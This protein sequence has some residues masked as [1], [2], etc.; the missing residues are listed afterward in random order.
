MKTVHL[1][2]IIGIAIVFAIENLHYVAAECANKQDGLISCSEVDFKAAINKLIYENSEHPL[3]LVSG[4]PGKILSLVV[5][6]DLGHQKLSDTITMGPN[7]TTTYSIDASSYQYGIYRAIISDNTGKVI[8]NFPV[9]LKS[10]GPIS[11]FTDKDHY[12]AGDIIT[13][14]GSMMPSKYVQIL[15]IDPNLLTQYKN[16]TYSD[17]TGHFVFKSSLPQFVKSGYW[18]IR[19]TSEANYMI[20]PVPVGNTE[21]ATDPVAPPPYTYKP[22]TPLQQIRSGI[23]TGDVLCRP[24]LQL[25]QSKQDLPACVRPQTAQMLIAR[26]W[27][28]VVYNPATAGTVANLSAFKLNLSTDNDMIRSGQKIGIDISFNN[29]SSIPLKLMAQDSRPYPSL[30]L[31]EECGFRSSI[32]IAILD[33][34]YTEQNVTQGKALTIFGSIYAVSCPDDISSIQSY[35]FEPSSSHAYESFCDSSGNELSSCGGFDN[36][37]AHLEINGT[38]ADGKIRPFEAGVY[39]LIGGDEWGDVAVQHFTISNSNDIKDQNQLEKIALS[40]YQ[41]KQIV[42]GRPYSI[43]GIGYQ[44]HAMENPAKWNPVVSINVANVTEVSVTIDGNTFS[45][46]NASSE[47]LTQVGTPAWWYTGDLS[48]KG[49]TIPSP[50]Y[51]DAIYPVLLMQPNSTSCVK[52]TYTII[53]HYY[54]R[55]QNSVTWPRVE[56]F[57]LRIDDWHYYNYGDGF[58]TTSGKDYTS[59]FKIMTIPGTVDLANYPVGSNFTVTYIIKPLANATGFYDESIPMPVC[60]RYPLAVGYTAEQVNSSDF[61]DGMI[62]M[63]SHSCI[64]GQE[65]LKA[66]EISGMNYTEMK[67]P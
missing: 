36:E 62:T 52:L 6:D 41:V 3:I 35:V 28:T 18:R 64:N 24:D 4:T 16:G 17:S 1:S 46:I 54:E 65:E 39:T 7:G 23:T 43:L 27:A 25:V 61:S 67:L 13:V 51:R 19:A 20:L 10:S 38:W 9:V 48:C 55:E 14:S 15:L 33:G 2:I 8:L 21:D 59:S 44:S 5:L 11:F 37:A 63:M 45:M 12:N 66:V 29:T 60:T 47:P 57:P 32:G 56:S 22:G 49:T 30:S 26:G 40:N 34:Y 50:N 42:A 31:G 58:G 53:N